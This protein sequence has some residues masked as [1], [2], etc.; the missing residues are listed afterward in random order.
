MTTPTT[1]RSYERTSGPIHGWFSLTYANFL[2][3]PR[4]VLQSMPVEWQEQFVGLLE[5]LFAAY[6]HVEFPDYEVTTVE[7]RY[8]NELSVQERDR[9]GITHEE[10]LDDEAPDG[11]TEDSP[12]WWKWVKDV[13]ID[14]NGNELNGGEHIGVPVADPIPHYRHSYLP[15]DEEAIARVRKA[16]TEAV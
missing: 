7:D 10:R 5:E 15:P 8:V 16:R 2:V 12:D 13:Y 11:L 3:V 1:E 4:A 9:L 14:R 6:Q